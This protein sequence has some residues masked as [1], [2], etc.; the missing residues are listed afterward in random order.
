MLTLSIPKN[1]DARSSIIIKVFHVRGGKPLDV[2]Y[3]LITIYMQYYEA[4]LSIPSKR[5][6]IQ[7]WNEFGI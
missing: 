3:P 2:F 5:L 7:V 4:P 6:Q 1:N